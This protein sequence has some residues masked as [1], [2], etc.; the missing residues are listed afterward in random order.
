MVGH[1]NASDPIT[2]GLV[3]QTRNAEDQLKLLKA[4]YDPHSS[5]YHHWLNTGQFDALYSASSDQVAAAT[6]FLTAA[7]LHLNAG[8]SNNRILVADGTA[9][10]VEQAF[11]TTIN[12]YRLGSGKVYYANSSSVQLP[13]HLQGIVADVLGLSDVAVMKT[14]SNVGSSQPNLVP[15]YGG[16]PFGRGLTPQ[17]FTS[18]YDVTPVY[19]KLNDRGQNITLA[20]YELS[21]YTP[22]DISHYENT[23]GLRHVPVV[24]KLVLGGTTDHS[25][26]SEVQLDI[27]FEIATAPGAKQL[28]VYM[29][30]NNNLSSLDEFLQMAEDNQADVISTSWGTACDFFTSTQDVQVENQVFVQMSLQ[31]QSLFDASGD[32]GAFGCTAAGVSLPLPEALQIGDPTSQPYIT[33]VGG[34]SFRQGGDGPFNFDPGT[35][36][37]P[38]YPGTSAEDVWVDVCTPSSCPGGGS[39]GGIGRFWGSGD[40]VFDPTTG[41]SLPG[42][43]EPQFSQTGSYCGQQ[44]G[45]LCREAP[46]VSLDADPDTGFALYCT[47][48]SDA[49]CTNPAI[50]THHWLRIGGTSCSSPIWAGIAA[51]DD[52][53]HNSRLGLFNYLLYPFDSPAG[54]SKQFHDITS[55][56]NGFY[57]AGPD[58]DLATG[59]GTPDVFNLLAA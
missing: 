18:I 26:A 22:G 27:D 1:H 16:G 10:Q 49:F 2:I 58:Y 21:N 36:P 7:G 48:Q 46:D 14:Q 12:D 50:D 45:I 59:I 28:L 15:P 53:L 52:S 42:V 17:Q 24:N 41:Q 13:A 35:N 30:A 33:T 56:N 37:H 44:P 5:S 29:A 32:S 25:G 38:K 39:A 43:F 8:A 54:Y 6:D 9:S 20:V 3:L 57:P 23:F 47:D 34:T 19:N 51:L 55:G 4:L 40:Y 11:H 31:G